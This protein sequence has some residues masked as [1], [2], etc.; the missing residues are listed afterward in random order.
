MKNE[1]VQERQHRPH[2]PP[3]RYEW[4][5]SAHNDASLGY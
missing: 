2:L 3:S 5:G 1:K 4:Q